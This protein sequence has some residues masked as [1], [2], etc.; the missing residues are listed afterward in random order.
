MGFLSKQEHS[1]PEKEKSFE[2]NL[3]EII[4]TQ[5]VEQLIISPQSFSFGEIIDL[6][7]NKSLS[8][9]KINNLLPYSKAII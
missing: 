2:I 8:H 1:F 5:Q 7:Q 9:L 4:R 3:T 6:M